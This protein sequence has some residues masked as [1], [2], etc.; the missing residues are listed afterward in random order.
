VV[1]IVDYED[2]EQEW[3]NRL[4]E[5]GADL[6]R[7]YRLAPHSPA[8]GGPR[9]TIAVH[10][11]LIRRAASLVSASFLIVDS[12]V[13]ALPGLDPSDPRAP[14]V[15]FRAR[16]L[17]TIGLPSSTLAHVNRA[18]DLR[19][20][21]GSVFWHN[22]ARLTWSLSIDASGRLVLANRKAND[23]P[24]GG[25]FQLLPGVKTKVRGQGVGAGEEGGRFESD[26]SKPAKWRVAS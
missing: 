19:Y 15:Y 8:W 11:L 26:D 18:E 3:R 5:C 6:T 9:G 14:Q 25:R 10:A 22:L 16:A 1:L 4:E 12:A 20:P 24:F 21:F 23:R 17:Q 2:H 13:M 7:V